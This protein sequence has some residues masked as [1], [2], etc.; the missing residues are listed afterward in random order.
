MATVFSLVISIV[1]FLSVSYFTDNLKKGWEMSMDE[2]NYDIRVSANDG[3]KLLPLTKLDSIADWTIVH[4][5]SMSTFIEKEDASDSL[6][7][8]ELDLAT[9]DGKYHYNLLL[10]ALDD[11][12]FN[13]Y[14]KKV[15]ADPAQW[16]D[17]A[18][19][20]AIVID[21]VVMTDYSSGS[22]RRV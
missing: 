14:A 12:S 20:G 21:E 8:G 1:L 13:E 16:R 4:E 11:K 2:T 9:E 5:L 15:G 3:E 18:Y 19:A 7:N 22:G 6:R 17:P 10:L